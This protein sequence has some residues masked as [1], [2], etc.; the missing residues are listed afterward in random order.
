MEWQGYIAKQLKKHDMALLKAIAAVV[1]AEAKQ[2]EKIDAEI[3]A[4]LDLLS[5]QLD[6]L[7]EGL[8]KIEADPARPRHCVLW[9]QDPMAVEPASVVNGYNYNNS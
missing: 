6:E 9:A 2:R 5:T 7:R 3:A 1:V 4:K 8:D